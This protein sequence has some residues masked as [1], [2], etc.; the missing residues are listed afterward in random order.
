M[1]V[2]LFKE[3]K[4][5]PF[6]LNIFPLRGRVVPEFNRKE[7]REIF[8]DH[9]RLIYSVKKESIDILA[10]IHIWQGICQGWKFFRTLDRTLLLPWLFLRNLNS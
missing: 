1:Q 5:I 6:L 10:M 8:V 9:Y 2:I 4:P 3:R 7:I